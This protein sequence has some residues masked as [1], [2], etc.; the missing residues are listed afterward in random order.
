MEFA[1]TLHLAGQPSV[2]MYDGVLCIGER[3]LVCH[4]WRPLGSA[5][6]LEVR[7]LIDDEDYT[8]WSELCYGQYAPRVRLTLWTGYCE[9]KT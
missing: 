4:T 8:F 6:I 7:G 1:G 2:E 3:A 5:D 9:V